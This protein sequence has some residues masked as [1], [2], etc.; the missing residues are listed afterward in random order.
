MVGHG[1]PTEL[2]SH[3]DV[4]DITV[5]ARR[6]A[7]IRILRG[8]LVAILVVLGAQGWSGDFFAVF[9]SPA[10]GITPPP[11]SLVGFLHELEIL[12]TPLI[13]LWHASEGIVLV[14]LAV[15]VVA[16]AWNAS[17]A[18]G[19][20]FWSVVGLLSVLSAGLGGLLFVKSGFGEGGSSMQMGG[21]YIGA[22][23]SYFLVL[24]FSK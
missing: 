24:Y 5:K 6:P 13:P 9:V 3:N 23:A 17:Q 19:L 18:R 12:P 1:F 7:R 20:R 22:L 16:L 4:I 8:L 15:A 2:S 10:G 11:L 21:S 14:V